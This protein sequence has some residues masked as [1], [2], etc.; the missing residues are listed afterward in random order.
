MAGRGKNK[1]EA[2]P[3][4]APEKG[5]EAATPTTESRAAN[6]FLWHIW[7]KLEVPA[8]E[9][10]VHLAVTALSLLSIALIEFLL[11]LLKLD[12]Q[13]IPGTRVKLSELLF[14]LEVV[15]STLIISIG[16]LKAVMAAWRAP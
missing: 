15:A 14:F 13:D 4:L 2:A 7:S 1:E 5:K 16:M 12:N 3:T 9:I 11:Y 10:L 8:V 6:K